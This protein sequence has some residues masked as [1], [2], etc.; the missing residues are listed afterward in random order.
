MQTLPFGLLVSFQ[1]QRSNKRIQ[2]SGPDRPSEEP[3]FLLAFQSLSQPRLSRWSQTYL[4]L[5]GS[6]P[7]VNDGI[8][9]RR[10]TQGWGLFVIQLETGRHGLAFSHR[11]VWVPSGVAIWGL[12]AVIHGL[13]T[14]KIENPLETDTF[15]SNAWQGRLLLT[16]R[17][18]WKY[19][20]NWR[21]TLR[22]IPSLPTDC[23]EQAWPRV[24]F[25]W[26]A[27]KERCSFI[28]SFL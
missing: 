4:L 15:R 28:P 6:A 24:G 23:K 25:L 27:H 11:P 19:K 12:S 9:W 7:Q 16:Q 1:E 22:K 2:T 21:M 18:P 14:E 17:S 8:I 5:S 20:M 26:K 10:I 13:G 3:L